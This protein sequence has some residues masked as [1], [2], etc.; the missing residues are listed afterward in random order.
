[1][2]GDNARLWL[3]FALFEG[4]V[5]AS[6]GCGNAMP[7]LV[8]FLFV[9]LFLAALAGAAMVYLAFFVGPHTRE[10]TIRIPAEKLAPLTP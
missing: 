1:V 10:M 5:A 8:R 7:S 6:G 2:F 3:D 4:Q 9:L